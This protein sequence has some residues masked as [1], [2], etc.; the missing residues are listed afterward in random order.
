MSFH[1]SYRGYATCLSIL[2]KGFTVGRSERCVVGF[3]ML[4][5]GAKVSK[6]FQLYKFYNR[7][8]IIVVHIPSKRSFVCF[9]AME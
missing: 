9:I 2:G 4:F 5:L 8:P 7:N 3:I 6:M 1:K